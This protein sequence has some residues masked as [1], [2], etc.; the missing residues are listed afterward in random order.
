MFC[1]STTD[2]TESARQKIAMFSN[3]E[4]DQIVC[5]KDC[6]SIYAVPVLFEEQQIMKLFDKRLELNL[7]DPCKPMSMMLKW[8]DLAER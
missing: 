2:I 6:S 8:K 3:L 7:A 5:V 1:R 4:I